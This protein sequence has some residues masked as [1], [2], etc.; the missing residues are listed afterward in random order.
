VPNGPIEASESP[1]SLSQSSI[2]ASS[3]AIEASES[4]G[5]PS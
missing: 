2:E 5:S 4:L 3:L 1:S